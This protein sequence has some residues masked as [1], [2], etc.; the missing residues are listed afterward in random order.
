MIS[1]EEIYDKYL[2]VIQLFIRNIELLM[3]IINRMNKIKIL[4]NVNVITTNLS[5]K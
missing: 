4:L 5:E 2:N 1:W 3:K